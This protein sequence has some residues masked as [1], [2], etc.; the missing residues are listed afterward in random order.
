MYLKKRA[1]DSLSFLVSFVAVAVQG[2]KR[3]IS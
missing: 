3:S 2:V 1:I